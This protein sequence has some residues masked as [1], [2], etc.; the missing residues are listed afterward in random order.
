MTKELLKHQFCPENWD[1]LK[2]N[3]DGK[4]CAV[5]TVNLVDLSDLSMSEIIQNHYGK[6]ACVRLTDSQIDFLSFYRK[7][8][9]TV[10]ISCIAGAS[11]FNHSY[12][13]SLENAALNEDS[14]LVTGRAVFDDDNR[15]SGNVPIYVTAGGKTFETQTDS[16]GNFAINLPKNCTVL[17]SNLKK[18]E[19]K[20]IK[21]RSQLKLG[22]NKIRR[23]KRRMGWL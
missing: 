12:S 19:S 6:G 5:C 18:L 1:N 16:E 13:Q 8:H 10:I 2:P 4:F 20:K 14:C 7:F 3:G 22:K 15:P 17:Y 23:D 9:K 21:N 11:F